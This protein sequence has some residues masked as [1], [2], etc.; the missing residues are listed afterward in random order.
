MSDGQGF[1]D[2]FSSLGKFTK[3]KLP[4][5]LVGKITM[6]LVI[7]VLCLSAIAI[8]S[9]DTWIILFIIIIIATSC[10]LIPL[11]LISFANKNPQAALLEGAEFVMHEQ[12][13]LASKTSGSI[14]FQPDKQVFGTDVKLSEIGRAH[15]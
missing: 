6:L 7:M 4:N 2:V 13:Q 5:G 1:P 9:N 12:I 10:I 14:P 11:R 8:R 3:V 15:V